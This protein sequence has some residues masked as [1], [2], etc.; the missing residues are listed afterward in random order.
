MHIILINVFFIEEKL[1][2]YEKYLQK[3][4]CIKDQ[5]SRFKYDNLNEYVSINCYI[6]NR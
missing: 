1:E 3:K 6:F 2:N 4:Q 5:F